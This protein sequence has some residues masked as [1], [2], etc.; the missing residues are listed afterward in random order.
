MKTIISQLKVPLLQYLLGGLMPALIFG[1]V[2]GVIIEYVLGSVPT[3]GQ[4]VR[5]LILVAAAYWGARMSAR[6][7]SGRGIASAN[8]ARDARYAA[9]IYAVVHV[10]LVSFLVHSGISS[11]GAT[12]LLPYFW[13]MVLGNVAALVVFYR[14]SRKYLRGAASQPQA[15]A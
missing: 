2:G 14:R 13:I 8:P 12:V 6:W 3:L 4:F 10:V 9:I 15:L 5:A 11:S 7:L 1:L